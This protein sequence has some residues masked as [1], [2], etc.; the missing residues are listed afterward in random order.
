MASLNKVQLIGN[1]GQD[2]EVRY[3][4][5]GDAVT[6]LS[7]ATTDEWKDKASGEKRQQTEWHR[8]VMYKKLAEIAAQHLSKGSQVYVE[9]RI[10]TK[11]W[12]DKDG[13]ERYTTQVDAT[14]LKFL[15]K[16]E[17]DQSQ[18]PSSGG[19]DADDDIPFN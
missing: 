12:T 14:E 15:G 6:T 19:N 11:N 1:L 4:A 9:G 2:P 3:T 7:V 17:R 13:V 16:R 5:G 10:K 8:V 18:A